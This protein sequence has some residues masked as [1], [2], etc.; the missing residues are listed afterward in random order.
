VLDLHAGA[1]AGITEATRSKDTDLGGFAVPVTE[2]AAFPGVVGAN[3]EFHSRDP[4]WTAALEAHRI[5]AGNRANLRLRSA[6]LP[7]PKADGDVSPAALFSP[8]YP[9][10]GYVGR[11]QLLEDLAAWRERQ[12]TDGAPVGLWFVTASGGYGKT[13]LAVQACVEAEPLG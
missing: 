2:L 6:V 12:T 11:V 3:E 9:I 8:H 5:R 10:V 7:P 4:R 1:V 13:R